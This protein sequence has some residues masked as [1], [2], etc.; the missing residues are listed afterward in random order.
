[1][2]GTVIEITPVLHGTDAE[3]LSGEYTRWASTNSWQLINAADPC[4]T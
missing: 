1:M 2:A 4:G 3:L